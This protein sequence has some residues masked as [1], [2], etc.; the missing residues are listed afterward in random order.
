MPAEKIRSTIANFIELMSRTAPYSLMLKLSYAF[1]MYA[2]NMRQTVTPE[3][4]AYLI[5]LLDDRFTY[6]QTASSVIGKTKRPDMVRL[7]IGLPFEFLFGPTKFGMVGLHPSGILGLSKDSILVA[8]L[9]GKIRQKVNALVHSVVRSGINVNAGF[10]VPISD[11]PEVQKG[12][13]LWQKDLKATHSKQMQSSTVAAKLYSRKTGKNIGV[14]NK[15]FATFIDSPLIIAMMRVRDEPVI[16]SIVTDVKVNL[17]KALSFKPKDDPSAYDMTQ[18]EDFAWIAGVQFTYGDV[19]DYYVGKKTPCPIVSMDPIVAEVALRMGITSAADDQKKVI[20]PIKAEL[21]RD[22][23]FPVAF[24]E[25]DHIL[26]IL[27]DP[28]TAFD[29]YLIRLRLTAMGASTPTAEKVSNMMVGKLNLFTFAEAVRGF[30]VSDQ[31]LGMLNVGPSGQDRVA[32]VEPGLLIDPHAYSLLRDF[33]ASIA[34][35][36][37]PLQQRLRKVHISL[38]THA[39]LLLKNKSSPVNV[40]GMLSLLTKVSQFE[41]S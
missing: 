14:T 28:V 4:A 26:N 16:S 33:A 15:G 25:G 17:V 31:F 6:S 9:T 37:N 21:A 13:E 8:T 5:T 27:R 2:L 19:V 39:Q 7:R 3:K 41:K 34:L 36:I 24:L 29:T 11:I 12:V 30:S 35:T 22:K 38:N 18:E 10:Q 20:Q 23:S 40:S 32:S 1:S